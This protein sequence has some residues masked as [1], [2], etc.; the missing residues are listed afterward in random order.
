MYDKLKLSLPGDCKDIARYL[1]EAK[2][3]VDTSTG[4][5]TTK[6]HIKGLSVSVY[7]VGCYLVGSLSKYLYGENFYPLD[8]HTTADAI[9]SLSDDLHTDVGKADIVGLEF[10]TQF[11]MKHKP[12]AYID[13]LGDLTRRMRLLA[14]DGTLYYQ[15]KGK[16]YRSKQKQVLCF[17]DK[18]AEV[19]N[20]G[21]TLPLGFEDANMLKYELRMNGSI[22]RRMKMQAVTASTLSERDFYLQLAKMWG[23]EY[24]KIAKKGSMKQAAALKAKSVGEAKDIFFARLLLNTPQQVIDEY[25]NELKVNGVFENRQY[26]TRLRQAIMGLSSK[27]GISESDELIRELDD[28]IRTY[29]SNA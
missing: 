11:P 2:E 26:Y 6:G 24:F 27:V 25:L 18:A 22:A 13:K 10:G 3:Q 19:K 9:E 8:R 16:T 23:D 17:Y 7:P 5:M 1:D 15:G 20:R 29:V 21:G 4:E 28:T 14:A 12:M